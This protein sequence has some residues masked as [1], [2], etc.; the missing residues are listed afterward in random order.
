MYS[1]NPL[2]S[3]KGRVGPHLVTDKRPSGKRCATIK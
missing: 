3:D 1:S 2:A